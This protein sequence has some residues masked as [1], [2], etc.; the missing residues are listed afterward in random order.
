MS[1]LSHERTLTFCGD[2]GALEEDPKLDGCYVL[3]TDLSAAE[4]SKE[5]V[6]DHYGS[7][8]EV[9]QVF[10]RS[11]TVELEMRPVH[12]R[13]ESSTRGHQLVVMLA[14]VL[15]QELGKR[16]AHLDLTVKEGLERLN[17][18][19]VVEVPEPSRGCSSHARTGTR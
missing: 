19:C 12:V 8:G 17:T 4:A 9:E 16:W 14:C 13:N 5:T 10:R 1:V 15:M 2:S 6:H 18:Y 3:R 7:R 11:R